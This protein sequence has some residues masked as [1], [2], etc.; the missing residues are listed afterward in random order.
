MNNQ[1]HRV[2]EATR[3]DPRS[4]QDG[5]K[6][7]L[8]SNLFDVNFCLQFGAV[9]SLMLGSIW[10]TSWLRPPRLV[11]PQGTQNGLR[12]PMAPK[13]P[14]DHPRLSPRCP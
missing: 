9:V 14:Q 4:A 12:R 2:Q 8:K 5:P 6:T 13:M 10:V 7:I 11:A 3:N 1:Q